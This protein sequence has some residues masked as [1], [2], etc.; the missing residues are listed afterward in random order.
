MLIKKDE[1]KKE[2]MTGNEK[3]N[4]V[5]EKLKNSTEPGIP[6]DKVK[7]AKQICFSTPRKFCILLLSSK[8]S[9]MC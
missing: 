6:Q 2:W 9:T 1:E 5:S 8:I 7:F 3:E 4:T